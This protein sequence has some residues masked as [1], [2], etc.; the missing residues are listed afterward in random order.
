[1][2]LA[3][4]DGRR[5]ASVVAKLVPFS[6]IPGVDNDIR[7]LMIILHANVWFYVDVLEA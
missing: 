6:V 7:V 1:M 3:V 2:L 5:P 4:A